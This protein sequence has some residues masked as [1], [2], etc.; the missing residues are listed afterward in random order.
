MMGK[1]ITAYRFE[2]VEDHHSPGSGRYG[3]LV[4]LPEDISAVLPYLNGML[5]ETWYD[6]ENKVLIGS[7]NGCRYAFRPHE[8]QI[9][10][11]PDASA[12]SRSAGEAVELVNRVWLER[13]RMVP[14]SR[15]R[16]LPT[17]YA[18][19]RL[20]PRSHCQKQCG[21]PSCLAFAADLRTGAVS[22]EQCPLL[23]TSEY[24]DNRKQIV[25]LFSASRSE[26]SG[27]AADRG[28]QKGD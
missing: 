13:D 2:L 28:C 25:A 11:I 26:G 6:Q 4:T 3:V 15:E 16:K 12:A 9:G 24:A 23:S 17:I 21:R 19:F 7:S 5:D 18:L 8:I 10:M 14:S 27:S 22:L 1:L 20:L